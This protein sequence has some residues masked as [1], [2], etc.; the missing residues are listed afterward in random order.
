MDDLDIRDM[1]AIKAENE[2]LR[3]RLYKLEEKPINKVKFVN[4]SQIYKDLILFFLIIGP[5]LFIFC[6]GIFLIRRDYYDRNNA[7]SICWFVAQEARSTNKPWSPYYLWTK[8]KGKL[9]TYIDLEIIQPNTKQVYLDL[10]KQYNL[11]ICQ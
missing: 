2:I 4:L 3:K 6:F 5:P 11:S 9:N 8:K 1:A 7:T 10:I